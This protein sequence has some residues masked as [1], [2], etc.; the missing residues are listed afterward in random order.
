[1]DVA[2]NF[3]MPL[4]HSVS[5]KARV[6]AGLQ[7]VPEADEQIVPVP[8]PE[9]VAGVPDKIAMPGVYLACV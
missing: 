7:W 8:W 6:A 3:A 2:D 1:M 4:E 5:L 9:A